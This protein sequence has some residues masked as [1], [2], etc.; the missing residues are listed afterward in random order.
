MVKLAD[1][2]GASGESAVR[3]F[4]NESMGLLFSKFQ[5]AVIRSG[6]ELESLIYTAIP[7]QMITSLEILN[8]PA[9][10]PETQLPIQ[11]V[12]KPSR[13][14]PDNPQK[15][16]EADLLIVDNPNRRFWLVE[17]KEG[18]VFDTKKADGELSSLKNIT[19]WLA[20]E[21]AYRTQYFLCSFN[22]E[23]KESIVQGT[24]KRFSSDHVLTG[25]ELCEKISIDYDT[26]RNKRKE[27]Q[28]Q[29]RR[30]FLSTL[31]AIPEI[32]AEIEELL[33]TLDAPDN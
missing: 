15:S 2:K 14:D 22:Q 20:Q 17:V 26:L 28:T 11:V 9:Q 7:T 8:E 12:F 4:G 13:P 27:D 31:I 19:S 21:F 1:S 16:I 3:I 10:N 24:K 32:R 23:D 33:G 5:A 30:Y 25:R 18:Y 29:N 6:F